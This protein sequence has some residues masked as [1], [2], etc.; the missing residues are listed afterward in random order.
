MRDNYMNSHSNCNICLVYIVLWQWQCERV[1]M[2]P[3]L[4]WIVWGEIGTW[5]VPSWCGLELLAAQTVHTA[6]PRL[7]QCPQVW[8]AVGFGADDPLAGVPAD[9]TALPA[10][11]HDAHRAT[12]GDV[13]D[14][15]STFIARGW[16]SGDCSDRGGGRGYGV[17]RRW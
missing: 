13:A 15:V 17:N 10:G 6:L 2:L 9:W 3:I 16:L 11:P 14:D 12:L 8:F 5:P 7:P 1:K 4:M